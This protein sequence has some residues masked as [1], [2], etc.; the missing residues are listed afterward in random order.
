MKVALKEKKG[1]SA[2]KSSYAEPT[3]DD[4]YLGWDQRNTKEDRKRDKQI[5]E[6]RVSNLAIFLCRREQGQEP[7]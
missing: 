6:K 4:E 1:S 7:G 2:G 3:N 5:E